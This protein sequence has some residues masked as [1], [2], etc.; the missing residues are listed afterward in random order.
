[1]FSWNFAILRWTVL[2][3]RPSGM[4]LD[5]IVLDLSKHGKFLTTISL[6]KWIPILNHCLLFVERVGGG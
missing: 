4:I 3:V 2:L 5:L 6:N 1:M